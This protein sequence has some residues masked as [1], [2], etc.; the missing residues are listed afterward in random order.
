MSLRPQFPSVILKPGN[1]KG[2]DSPAPQCVSFTQG[3]PLVI[4]DESQHE[5]LLKMKFI[6]QLKPKKSIALLTFKQKHIYERKSQTPHSKL[7]YGDFLEAEYQACL[8]RTVPQSGAC[9]GKETSLFND[10]G[11]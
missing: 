8:L 10:I 1:T 9:W 11:F 4:S 5:T 7:P 6:L 3:P 2:K